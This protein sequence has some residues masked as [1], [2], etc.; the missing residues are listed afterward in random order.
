[1]KLVPIAIAAVSVL[2]SC[3]DKPRE[4]P[5]ASSSGP[6]PGAP[7]AARPPGAA[8]DPAAPD[9]CRS[10]LGTIDQTEC[11]TPE[12][13][14]GLLDTKKAIGG[15]IETIGKIGNPDVR[16]F[17]VMCA[18]MILAIERDAAKLKCAMTIDAGL[19]KEIAALIDAWY[20]Q[21]TP[22]AP[23]GDAAADAVIARI[24]AVRDAACVCQDAACLDRVD[25]Q[26]TGVGELP[27][28]A[29]AAART[30]GI[31]LLEDAERCASRL[32]MLG[33]SPR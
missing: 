5:P 8:P 22:V 28:A 12:L 33:S 24:A 10:S 18:Q 27:A 17:Q 3:K 13:Q 15:I 31:K 7:P 2:A 25:Q 4:S 1:M 21:R 29:P 26:L 23:T 16:Q 19:R 20:A 6:G 32:R 11:P 14:R 30:L 9:I